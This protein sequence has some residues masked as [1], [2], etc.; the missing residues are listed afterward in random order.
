MSAAPIP[1]SIITLT[2]DVITL[3]LCVSESTT[4][5]AEAPKYATEAGS[6]VN[7]MTARSPKKYE[8]SG[9][10]TYAPLVD[11]PGSARAISI[12]DRLLSALDLGS[13]VTIV[14]EQ[15]AA[16][17]LLTTVKADKSAEDGE[18]IRLSISAE[19]YREVT[20]GL[21]VMP[22]KK[23][24]AGVRAGSAAAGTGSTAAKG[25][26]PKASLLTKMTGRGVAVR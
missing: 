26:A 3:D 6:S 20:P 23:L 2:G 15:I 10:L 17:V 4:A 25:A 8:L 24:A 11:A 16:V 9:W 13:P 22:A 1:T 21:T 7:G 14:S 12:R 18:A 19:E 5:S